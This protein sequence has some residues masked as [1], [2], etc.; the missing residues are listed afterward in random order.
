MA[1]LSRRPSAV[2]VAIAVALVASAGLGYAVWPHGSARSANSSGASV[3]HASPGTVPP[4]PSAA[5]ASGASAS[6]AAASKA[7]SPAAKGGVEPG[8][9]SVSVTPMARPSALPSS[10]ALPWAT[11]KQQASTVC[12]IQK[13][14]SWA[15]QVAH[16]SDA[17][18]TDPASKRY[19][20]Q[21]LG[22]G[23]AAFHAVLSG[24]DVSGSSADR[25]RRAD[26]LHAAKQVADAARTSGSAGSTS[27]AWQRVATALSKDSIGC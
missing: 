6:K 22:S 10:V 16:G 12:R 17:A 27:A 1:R 11:W 15:D 2:S 13:L 19:A 9:S 14:P 20:V 21:A 25:A 23:A 5:P 3:T 26:L 4:S 8:G 7:A 18:A 24:L